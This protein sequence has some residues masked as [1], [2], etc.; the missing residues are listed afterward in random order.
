MAFS[1]VDQFKAG[2]ITREQLFEQW[3]AYVDQFKTSDVDPIFTRMSQAK[4]DYFNAVL[5]LQDK[6]HEFQ[7]EIGEVDDLVSPLNLGNAKSIDVEP[8]HNAESFITKQ[9][10]QGLALSERTFAGVTR[11]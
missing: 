7:K 8:V 6:M 10:L 1:G 9:E 2:T 5:D 3:G 4:N 11:V